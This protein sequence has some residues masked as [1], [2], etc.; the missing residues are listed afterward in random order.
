[1]FAGWIA[2]DGAETLD[3]ARH[4]PDVVPGEFWIGMGVARG[5][6]LERDDALVGERFSSQRKSLGLTGRLTSLRCNTG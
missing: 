5:A 1:L 2:G 6:R 3:P 4:H